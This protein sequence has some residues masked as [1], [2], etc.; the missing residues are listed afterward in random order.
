MSKA[1]GKTVSIIALSLAFTALG[2]L[3]A[4]AASEGYWPR[5]SSGYT[6]PSPAFHGSRL[7]QLRAVAVPVPERRRRLMLRQPSGEDCEAYPTLKGRTPVLAP[8]A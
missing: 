3:A 6:F 8:R 1:F 7:S 2:T 4:S 5:N